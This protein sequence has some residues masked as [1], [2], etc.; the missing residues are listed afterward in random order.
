MQPPNPLPQSTYAGSVA[1]NIEYIDNT[2]TWGRHEAYSLDGAT[3]LT[4]RRTGLS[5]R[6]VEAALQFFLKSEE[7]A[8][9]QTGSDWRCKFHCESGT[10]GCATTSIHPQELQHVFSQWSLFFEREEANRQDVRLCFHVVCCGNRTN[11]SPR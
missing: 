10:S 4:K 1:S 9:R 2:A 8:H 3:E 6:I 5:V 11:C 7:V